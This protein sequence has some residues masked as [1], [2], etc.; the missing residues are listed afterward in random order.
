MLHTFILLDVIL[1]NVVFCKVFRGV[2]I[3]T[4]IN[5]QGNQQFTQ[6]YCWTLRLI[7]S[8]I[9]YNI[10]N[11]F[12]IISHWFRDCICMYF[13]LNPPSKC[14]STVALYCCNHDFTL[15]PLICFLLHFP[16]LLILKS[17]GWGGQR[18]GRGKV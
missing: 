8:F 2:F 11:A 17:K 7:I 12:V 1:L 6:Y 10:K 3:R 13:F 15:Q 9:M 18:E 5:I 4:S 16:P 14:C